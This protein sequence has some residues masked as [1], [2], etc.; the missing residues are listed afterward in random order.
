MIVH[1]VP[2]LPW[3]AGIMAIT[4]TLIVGVILFDLGKGPHDD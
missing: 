4:L 2:I 1:T 3:I